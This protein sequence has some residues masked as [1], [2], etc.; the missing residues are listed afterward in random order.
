MNAKAQKTESYLRSS[1]G[2][3]NDTAFGMTCAS[4]F[5]ICV[6][7]RI[8]PRSL[9]GFLFFSGIFVI[10]SKDI[11][12]EHKNF[13]P[14]YRYFF[15]HIHSKNSIIIRIGALTATEPPEFLR[16]NQ[17][18]ATDSLTGSRQR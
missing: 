8:Y 6:N 16:S 11:L 18:K 4:F 7:F 9:T 12:S 17:Q 5:P 2:N 1:A 14:K 3:A 15:L 13:Y 10:L